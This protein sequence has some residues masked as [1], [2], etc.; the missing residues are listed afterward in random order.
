MIDAMGIILAGNQAIS[1]ITDNRAISALPVAGSYRL[2]DFVLSNMANAGMTN[3]GVVTSSNYSS[4]MDHIKSGKPW[5]LDR[6]EAGL[7]ILPPNMKKAQYGMLHG[8]LDM[9]DGDYEYIRRSKQTYV[10]LS[11][12]TSLYSI[13][14]EE[15]LEHHIETQADITAIYKERPELEKA[16]WQQAEIAVKYEGYIKRQCEQVERFEKNEKR[17]IPEDIDYSEV[18]GLRIEARQKL[19]KMRPENIGRASRISGVS[20]A[21]IGVLLIYISS[22]VK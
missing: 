15:I 5:D 17:L 21:D 10:I 20:P 12:G 19:E 3:V 8:N 1:P 4:L 13:D 9:L 14:F 7:N 22:K 11:L 16:V 6:K 2:I 18:Y